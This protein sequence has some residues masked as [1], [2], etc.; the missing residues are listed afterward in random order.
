MSEVVLATASE[1]QVWSNKYLKEYVRNSRFASYMGAADTSIIV[2]KYE[3]QEEA[4]KTI[5]IPLITK[6]DGD[7]VGGSEVLDGNEAE[8]GNHNCAISVDWVR[9]A[10]RVPKSSQYKTEINLLGAAKP[11]LKNWSGEDLRTDTIYAL[12]QVCTGGTYG[13]TT[14]AYAP[15]TK[16]TVNGGYEIASTFVAGTSF[17]RRKGVQWAS[18]SE[19]NKDAWVAANRD[20]VLFGASRSNI[21]GN[22]HSAALLN[23]DTTS[24]KLTCA[25][26]SLAKRMAQN[27]SPA[28]YPFTLEDGREF[29][30][31]FCGPR[32]FRDLKADPVMVAANRDA[33]SRE[34][35]GMSNNPLFQ[36]GDLQYDGIIYR[37]V[38]EIPHITGAGNGGADVEPN[39]L[40]GRQAVGVAWGQEPTPKTDTDKDFQFRPGV[41]I[42][43]L[44]GVKKLAYNSKQQG[45]VT[46]YTAAAAD[47]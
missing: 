27:A 13:D 42:E 30:V 36:D 12:M 37:E 39:F 40:C 7:G 44:R 34:G 46:V 29:F 4:G 43:E 26:G 8:L 18:A 38:P 41:A 6:I 31:M 23:V 15:I 3:L 10:V 17:F 45:I 1:K 11:M 47:S 24:D 25:I 28:I 32:S 35:N 19:A 5:N 9:N 20:R 33:R 16:D 22:D 2:V 14:I 21:A